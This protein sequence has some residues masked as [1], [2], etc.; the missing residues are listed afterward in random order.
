M[1]DPWRKLKPIVGK[2]VRISGP[3]SWLPKSIAAPKR[4]KV[5]ESGSKSQLSLAESLALSLE[6]AIDDV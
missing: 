1:K 6:E 3:G 5:I 2:L 4:A